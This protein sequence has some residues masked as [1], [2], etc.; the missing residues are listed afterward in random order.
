MIRSHHADYTDRYAGPGA[1]DPGCQSIVLRIGSW[2]CGRTDK[3]DSARISC[4]YNSLQTDAPVIEV[5]QK[6]SVKTELLKS[7]ISTL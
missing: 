7:Q 6:E 1:V 4:V 3:L 2:T 5:E